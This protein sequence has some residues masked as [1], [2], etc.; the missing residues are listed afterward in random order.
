MRY[1]GFVG[2]MLMWVSC[3]DKKDNTLDAYDTV[4]AIEVE[5]VEVTDAMFGMGCMTEYSLKGTQDLIFSQGGSKD[6]KGWVT[7]MKINGQ[8]EVF[9]STNDIIVSEGE[10]KF[11]MQLENKNYWVI[12][13]AT[14]GEVYMESDASIASGTLKVIDKKTKEEKIF[15]FE[16]GTAC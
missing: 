10:N 6:E 15:E 4:S 14:V 5:K 8:Q 1:L 13:D 12:I 3:Q 2:L 16:G 9:F 11:S 7:Y